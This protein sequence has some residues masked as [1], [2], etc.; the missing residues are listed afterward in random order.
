MKPAPFAYA[1]PAAL[2]DVLALLAEHGG[3]AKPLAGGQSLLPIMNLRLAR[4][5][6]LV[7]VNRVAAL[8]GLVRDGDTVRIGATTRQ[9]ELERTV[10]G[11]L[12]LVALALRHVGHVAT[13]A[14]GTL[15]G[16]LVHADPAGE[17]PTVLLALDGEVVARSAA[18]GERVIAAA[19]FQL[20]TMT[21]ALAED[22]L[23]TEIRLPVRPR[24]HHGF[25][26]LARRHGD[27]ALVG[28]AVQAEL[29]A[30]GAYARVALALFGVA[31][32]PI[33]L[34][35]VEAALAG[36]RPE[37]AD[38]ARE[39]RAAVSAAVDPGGDV[40]ATGAYR[41]RVAGVVAARAL[42]QAVPT[43]EGALAA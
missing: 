11:D 27:F 24:A 20:T 8:T 4:P 23:L 32:R 41:K 15:G 36:R 26:E 30:D 28:A 6:L 38:V 31:D 14:R 16:S 7:D 22:E 19:D 43:M 3:D 35:E 10:A 21:T 1:A 40:H 2:D 9:L 29:D 5:V 17:L 18:R 33:R 37:D 42:A 25:V 12:P 13:R 34:P 39:V